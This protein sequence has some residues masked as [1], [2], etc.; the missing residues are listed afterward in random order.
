VN[1]HKQTPTA[2]DAEK[3]QQTFEPPMIT[4]EKRIKTG[5]R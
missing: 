2:E 4:D 1:D 5:R 3:K